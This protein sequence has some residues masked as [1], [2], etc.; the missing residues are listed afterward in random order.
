MM[1]AR[2]LVR[3]VNR[4]LN[5]C[6]GGFS[7]IEILCRSWCNPRR[8]L[9]LY[10]P[11]DKIGAELNQYVTKGKSNFSIRPG[12]PTASPFEKGGLRGIFPKTALTY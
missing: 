4:F 2:N 9:A 1:Y 10:A 8:N 3:F 12:I 6:T 11:S 7:R 5:L